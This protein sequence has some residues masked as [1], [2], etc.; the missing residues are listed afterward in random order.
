MI[1]TTQ[2]DVLAAVRAEMARRRI[3]QA[4]VAKALG[5][6]QQSFSRRLCGVT[7]LYEEEIIAIADVIGCRPN[8]LLRPGS[9]R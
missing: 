5:I 2:D 4:A 9:K 1:T 3:P 8:D 7:P 6:S